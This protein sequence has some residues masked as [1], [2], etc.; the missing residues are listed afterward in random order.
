MRE[1]NAARAMGGIRAGENQFA[2]KGECV[3]VRSLKHER[4]CVGHQRSVEAGRNLRR[5]WRSRFTSQAKNHF[6][7][8]HSLG[9]DPVHIRERPTA[10]MVIDADQKAVF[11][12]LKPSAVNAVT[13][14]NDG[15]LVIA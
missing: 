13:L 10:N 2:R 15:R 6:S 9:I 14:K 3:L 5:E 8:S 11:Q 1:I 4:S 7:S 12:A